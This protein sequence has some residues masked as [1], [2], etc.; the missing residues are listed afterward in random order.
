MYIRNFYPYEIHNII[1][2]CMKIDVYFII[3][4]L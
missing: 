4:K 1:I 3:V 2:K